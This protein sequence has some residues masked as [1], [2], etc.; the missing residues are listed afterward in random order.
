[1]S[2]QK[3]EKGEGRISRRT[4]LKGAAALGGAAAWGGVPALS[5]TS[6]AQAKRL[7]VVFRIAHCSGQVAFHI[8]RGGGVLLA[9]DAATHMARL[10]LMPGYEDLETGLRSLA[11]L[12]RF[13]FEVAGFGHGA[14]ILRGAAARFREKWG[15]VGRF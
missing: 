15:A 2:N 3:S 10:G 11:K 8:M 12:A 1:M 7:N 4:F 14:P 13:S 9:A 6:W 5:R